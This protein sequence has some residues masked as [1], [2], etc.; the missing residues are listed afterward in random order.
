MVRPIC[1]VA[2]NLVRIETWSAG[3]RTRRRG[4][5]RHIVTAPGIARKLG[6]D[7]R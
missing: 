1:R 6:H 5:V 2:I 4:T 3:Q 7:Q